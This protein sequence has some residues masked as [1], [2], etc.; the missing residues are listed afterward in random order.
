MGWTLLDFLCLDV[1]KGKPDHFAAT[2][3]VFMYYNTC[4]CANLLAGFL[5]RDCHEGIR[6]DSDQK[7][8][9][10]NSWRHPGMNK[11]R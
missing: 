1:Y 8:K 11:V 7:L 9:K 6:F 4:L 5:A 3:H 10:G 2:L